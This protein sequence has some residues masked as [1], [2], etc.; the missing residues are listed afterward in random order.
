MCAAIGMLKDWGGWSR[1][2][3]GSSTISVRSIE[4]ENP[5]WR[6]AGVPE[7]VKG[8]GL[9]LRCIVLRGFK[10]LPLHHY[11]LNRVMQQPREPST[12]C[13]DVFVIFTVAAITG[14]GY[15]TA[16]SNSSAICSSSPNLGSLT[17]CS[18]ALSKYS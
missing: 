9:K 4:S 18:R 10:S 16:S 1:Q 11:Y 14:S 7:L 3:I 5:Y 12:P 13:T 2:C 8:A 6:F 15:I 17:T